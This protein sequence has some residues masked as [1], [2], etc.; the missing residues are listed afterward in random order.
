MSLPTSHA[1]KFDPA[2]PRPQRPETMKAPVWN[3]V[4]KVA[5]DDVPRLAIG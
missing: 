2:Q 5:V 3:G 4:G 1:R